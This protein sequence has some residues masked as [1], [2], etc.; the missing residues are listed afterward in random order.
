MIVHV[1]GGTGGHEVKYMVSRIV[2]SVDDPA[3]AVV[4]Q[5]TPALLTLLE[6]AVLE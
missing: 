5:K 4:A 6:I 2:R 1:A 3:P